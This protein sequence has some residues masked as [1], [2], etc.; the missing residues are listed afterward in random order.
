MVRVSD[1]YFW[2]SGMSTE[3]SFD[4][5]KIYNK[6]RCLVFSSVKQRLHQ[7]TDIFTI[8]VNKVCFLIKCL[9]KME[10]IGGILQ[11][12]KQMVKQLYYCLLRCPKTYLAMVY[13]STTRT[14]PTQCQLVFLRNR[15]VCF[16][17][18]KFGMRLNHSYLKN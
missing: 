8:D 17:K 15:S 18:E 6:K 9:A 1:S 2:L 14:P 13:H 5:F 7:I 3:K 11:I 16:I 4:G 10:R 12:I